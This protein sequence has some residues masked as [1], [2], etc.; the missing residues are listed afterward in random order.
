MS[1]AAVKLGYRPKASSEK[2]GKQ[3]DDQILIPCD[4]ESTEAF[5]KAVEF[6]LSDDSTRTVVSHSKPIK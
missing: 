2:T 3:P 5:R 4:P 6:L 1:G